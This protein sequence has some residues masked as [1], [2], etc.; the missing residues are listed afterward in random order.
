MARSRIPLVSAISFIALFIVATA[1]VPDPPH[2]EDS[3]TFAVLWL[4]E[5]QDDIPIAAQLFT[6]A[7]IPFFVLV[8]W[9]RAA[10]PPLYGYAFL[11][12]A[13]AFVA[14]AVISIWFTAGLAL[15][16]DSLNPATARTLLD[17]SSQF[18]PILTTTDV[19]MAGAVALAAFRTDAFPRWLG[20]I[21]AVFALEQLVE[22]VTLYGDSG[23]AAP[24]GDWNAVLGGGFLAVWIIALGFGLSRGSQ[25]A[26]VA[27]S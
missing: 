21:S 12:A 13:G 25:P 19:V 7:V 5:H 22:S 14:E 3:G 11:A 9:V 8:A 1:L 27:T 17:I 16:A 26:P 18:G 20:W 23:F 2:V 15:H 24:G 6:L 10:L 4:R